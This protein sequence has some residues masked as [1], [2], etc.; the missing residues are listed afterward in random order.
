MGAFDC[1]PPCVS[2]PRAEPTAR[3]RAEDEGLAQPECMP[4]VSVPGVS[5]FNVK[6]RLY[7][8]VKPGR[9]RLGRGRR[10]RFDMAT[11][12]EAFHAGPDFA[13]G[14]RRLLRWPTIDSGSR[15]FA[16]R[17]SAIQRAQR[18]SVSRYWRKPWNA[19][20]TMRWSSSADPPP[21]SRKPRSTRTANCRRL[22]AK[23]AN[24]WNGSSIKRSIATR[25]DDASRTALG[26][27]DRTADDQH[28]RLGTIMTEKLP[29]QL[30]SI[31]N[32]L[33]ATPRDQP[34]P[35]PDR[36]NETLPLV[37]ACADALLSAAAWASAVA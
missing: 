9:L 25:Q 3:H 5:G 32:R 31:A 12:G 7:R 11:A 24:D 10:G 34:L 13:I 16:R 33:K 4:G 28:H 26:P 20:P 19:T 17:L 35:L 8:T 36:A 21:A 27:S 15:M 18:P 2:N 37:I 30:A 22:L 6:R 1:T 14:R 23:R 29:D